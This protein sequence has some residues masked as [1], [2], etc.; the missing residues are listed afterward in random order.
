MKKH[1]KAEVEG[2]VQ[3]VGFRKVTL[4]RARALDLVGIVKNL[5]NGNVYVEAS[6]EGKNIEELINFLQKGPALAAVTSV[7]AEELDQFTHPR[8]RF[9]I[10]Y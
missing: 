9:E 4:D 6:G 2:K 1:F 5:E 8:T 10:T 7:R 3:G